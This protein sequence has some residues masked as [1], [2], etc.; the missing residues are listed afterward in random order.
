MDTQGHRE[1]L[2]ERLLLLRSVTDP[3]LAAAFERVHLEQFIPRIFAPAYAIGELDELTTADGE[4]YFD[5]LYSGEAII[6]DLQ[7]G[8]PCAWE[9]SALI[10]GY[11]LESLHLRRGHSVLQL[12]ARPT[13]YVSRLLEHMTGIAP[14]TGQLRDVADRDAAAVHYERVVSHHGLARP[15]FELA[16][17]LSPDGVA[18]TPVL[19]GGWYQ[20]VQTDAGRS[21]RIVGSGGVGLMATGPSSPRVRVV[22]PE[23]RSV[24][25]RSLW[26]SL[27][28]RTNSILD[29]S[30]FIA[31]TVEG[32][33][34]V[35]EVT[36]E[37]KVAFKGPGVVTGTDW[38]MIP[39]GS[40]TLRGTT[41]GISLV[42]KAFEGW[43][44]YGEPPITSYTVFDT[45][46]DD[47]LPTW[48]HCRD[49]LT[50]WVGLDGA[51]PQQLVLG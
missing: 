12:D 1:R 22:R 8:H 9:P 45:P 50:W 32:A 20:L 35:A 40:N 49:T 41:A 43:Q 26:D 18:V 36:Q 23:Q 25:T 7:D 30:A 42:E 29:F 4:T 21:S 34:I 33:C 46:P 27:D 5:A 38:A 3:N 44:Q 51:G 10:I 28:I 24:S 19:H 37:N 48:V 13:Q 15:A 47:T 6:T 39:S 11:L 31:L 16:S 2:A 17:V 14:T